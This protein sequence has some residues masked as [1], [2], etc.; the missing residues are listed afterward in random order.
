MPLRMLNRFRA[1]NH[2]PP[3]RPV[4]TMFAACTETDAEGRRLIDRHMAEFT[5]SSEQTSGND[6]ARRKL[7]SVVRRV[8]Q[9]AGFGGATRLQLWGSPSRCIA[10]LEELHRAVRPREVVV[11][12]RYGS[13]TYAAAERSMRLFAETVLP[14]VHSWPS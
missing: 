14:V 9:G 12:F 8:A 10:R 7:R 4:L 5:A 3:S 6:V 13:M 1:A 11:A 2:Y